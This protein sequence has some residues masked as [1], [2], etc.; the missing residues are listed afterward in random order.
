VSWWII[1]T[2]HLTKTPTSEGA[3]VQGVSFNGIND[4]KFA[5]TPNEGNRCAYAQCAQ[6]YAIA[7]GSAARFALVGAPD[8]WCHKACAEEWESAIRRGTLSAAPKP[9]EATCAAPHPEVKGVSCTR[10]AHPGGNHLDGHGGGWYM[11]AKDVETLK[12]QI[13]LLAAEQDPNWSTKP[14]PAD[15]IGGPTE[16]ELAAFDEPAEDDGAQVVLEPHPD[17]AVIEAAIATHDH[18]PGED[19]APS[20]LRRFAISSDEYVTEVLAAQAK[21]TSTHP[22]TNVT[23]IHRMQTGHV[24][25]GAAVARMQTENTLLRV[26]LTDHGFDVDAVI[27]KGL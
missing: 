13:N 21:V 26:F 6:G 22:D 2:D 8:Q 12:D 18:A 14:P 11:D 27:L 17:E 7:E 1:G 19:A 20:S 10:A 23:T 16:A 5:P 25:L 9:E 3:P 4:K 24:D 15:V